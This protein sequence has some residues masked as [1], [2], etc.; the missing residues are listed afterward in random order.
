MFKILV[1]IL[2]IAGAAWM[3]QQLLPD[4]ERYLKLR[5]M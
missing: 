5:S 4:V 2:A 1:T 3:I